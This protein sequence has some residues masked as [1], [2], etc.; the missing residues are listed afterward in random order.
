[1]WSGPRGSHITSC[2]RPGRASSTSMATS[3]AAAFLKHEVWSIIE[4]TKLNPLL[5]TAYIYVGRDVNVS[6]TTVHVD[7]DLA[8]FE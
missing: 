8:G 1:M 6:Y 5:S 3:S 2:A 4:A 7:L